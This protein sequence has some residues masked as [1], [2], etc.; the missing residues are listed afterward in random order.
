MSTITASQRRAA[1]F[2]VLLLDGRTPAQALKELDI[3]DHAYV[4]R[5]KAKLQD[6]ASLAD[7]KRQGRPRKYNEATLDEAMLWVLGRVAPLWSGEEIVH[8]LVEEGILPDGASER[9][10]MRALVPHLASHGWRLVYGPQRLTFAMNQSH[11]HSR[12]EWCYLARLAFT[13]ST[14]GDWWFE[15]EILLEHGGAPKG[16]CAAGLQRWAGRLPCRPALLAPVGGWLQPLL[17][18]TPACAVH[19]CCPC[20]LIACLVVGTRSAPPAPGQRWPLPATSCSWG[21]HP[22]L[23][24]CV[25]ALPALACRQQVRS[26]ALVHPGG[27]A[28]PKPAVRATA[29]AHQHEAGRLRQGR[30]VTNCGAH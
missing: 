30:P 4:R 13:S 7:A 26:C 18:C 24:P 20:A 27:R 19:C 29:A 8:S 14:V 25:S 17:Q 23:R 11:A 16:E 5:L 12:L 21:H 6:S 10:F 9:S 3:T 1:N 22:A 15:D 28:P 2:L